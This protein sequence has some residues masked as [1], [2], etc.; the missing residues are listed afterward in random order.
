MTRKIVD[1]EGTIGSAETILSATDYA[2]AQPAEVVN[3]SPI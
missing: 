3:S 2:L 1:E